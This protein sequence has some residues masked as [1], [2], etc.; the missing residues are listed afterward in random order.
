VSAAAAGPEP[1][2]RVAG[3]TK[4]FPTRRRGDVLALQGLDLTVAA[5]EFVSV[6]GP[7]GCGKSTLLRLVGG[8]VEP[9]EGSVTV[10]G[11]SPAAAR[12]AKVFGF[13]PQTPALLPWQSVRANARLL[14]LVNRGA[15]DHPTLSADETEVLLREVGLGDFLDALPGEL[16]G[17][18][19]QRVA[20]VRAFALGP[21]ILLMDE[22]F[23]ALDEITRTEMRYL[24]LQLWERHGATALFVTHSI[25]EAVLLSDRVIVLAPRPGRVVAVE[26]VTLERPRRPEQEDTVGFLDHVARVRQ[27]LRGTPTVA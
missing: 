15:E 2:V 13:V 4:R 25:A 12:R 10:A 3:V 11:R 27:A 8:L 21:P 9:D 19:Q 6:I 22:P 14:T 1:L 18:M 20:L 16:S 17:G 23:A 24:L 7:S 26:A 5:G